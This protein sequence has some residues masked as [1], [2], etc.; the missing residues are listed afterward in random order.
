MHDF[1]FVGNVNVGANEKIFPK[2][3]GLTPY[4]DVVG[5]R[6][7]AAKLYNVIYGQF[8]P[9]PPLWPRPTPT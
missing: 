3:Q 2:Q 1:F 9:L 6:A 4:V 8:W 7:A 5:A